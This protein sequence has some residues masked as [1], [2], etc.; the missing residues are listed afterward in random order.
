ML[1]KQDVVRL[2]LTDQTPS[3]TQLEELAEDILG[4][5]I[6]IGRIKSS[7][8]NAKPAAASI[9]F[10]YPGAKPKDKCLLAVYV[11]TFSPLVS[12]TR[13]IDNTTVSFTGVS[14]KLDNVPFVNEA[15]VIIAEHFGLSD[16]RSQDVTMTI[17]FAGS[18]INPQDYLPGGE[19]AFIW[20]LKIAHYLNNKL[21]NLN[22][23][24]AA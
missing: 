1:T 19:F 3:V 4:Q 15:G 8:I 14:F 9:D 2:L 16:N 24:S 11:K 21:W 12:S 7:D 5:H 6:L 10:F 18:G 13:D 20:R 17:E 22:T 23:N